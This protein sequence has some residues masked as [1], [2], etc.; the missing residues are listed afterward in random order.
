MVSHIKNDLRV[1]NDFRRNGKVAPLQDMVRALIKD[2]PNC[3]IS[4]IY[5]GMDFKDDAGIRRVIRKMV[6]SHSI[7]QR[8]NLI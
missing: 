5:K 1:I 7:V 8:F 4:E 3:T 2:H 6:E